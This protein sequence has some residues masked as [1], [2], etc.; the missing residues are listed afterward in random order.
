MSRNHFQIFLGFDPR[1]AAAFAVARQSIRNFDKHVPISGL[2]LSDLQ[3]NGMYYRA[4]ERRLGQLWD[5]ISDAPMSTEF[6]ISR[7]LVPAIVKKQ[8]NFGWALFADSDVLFRTNPNKLKEQLDDSKAVMCVKHTH[9]P[10]YS[11]KMDGQ[12]QTSYARKNWSSVLAFNTDHPS[13]KHLT[14]EMVNT[15]PGRDL[16][17]LCWLD[18][19]EIGGLDQSWNFLVGHTDSN[20][21]PD[22]VHFTDGIPVFHG[23]RNVAFADDWFRELDRWAR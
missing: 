6:A 1:E 8:N 11:E 2:V 23:F 20:V 4:T 7:F 15:L 5:K 22:L 14:V 16:H 21:E 10:N 13:N 3:A 19:D 12:I 18:D 17:R 9:N